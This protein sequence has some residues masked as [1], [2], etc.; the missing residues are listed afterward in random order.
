MSQPPKVTAIPQLNK[1]LLNDN[2]LISFP[3]RFGRVIS[4]NYSKF[5]R[6]FVQLF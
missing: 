3:Q 5:S 1:L 6:M 2:K 4:A